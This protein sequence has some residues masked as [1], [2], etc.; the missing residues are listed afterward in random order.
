MR[1][2]IL[3]LAVTLCPVRAALAWGDTGHRIICEIAFQV[4]GAVRS[5]RSV[6]ET[7]ETTKLI[8]GHIVETFVLDKSSG[9]VGSSFR[10]APDALRQKGVGGS[11]YIGGSL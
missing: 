3:V 2:V 1:V 10:V 11:A 4:F 7:I 6:A 8:A 9:N 5:R